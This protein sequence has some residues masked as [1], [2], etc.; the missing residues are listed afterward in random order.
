MLNRLWHGRFGLQ[1]IAQLLWLP[2]YHALFMFELE[3]NERMCVGTGTQL[4]PSTYRARL[5][6]E[7]AERYDMRRQRQRR[8]ELA[9]ARHANNQWAW[10][11]SLLARSVAYYK[12]TTNFMRATETGQRRL[13]SRPVT[14]EFLRMMRDCQ[15]APEWPEG[16]HVSVYVADQTYQWVGVHKHGRRGTLERHDGQGMPIQIQ[17]EVYINS[18]K[19]MA[20]PRPHPR[21]RPQP[22]L[23]SPLAP[24]LATY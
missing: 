2:T 5:Q 23:P 9:I 4:P 14:L 1:Q 3:H 13:A 24:R 22:L 17:H 7:R 18:I 19:V 16:R 6:G 10:S 8:D 21:P 11:P 15:P 20:R 12:H